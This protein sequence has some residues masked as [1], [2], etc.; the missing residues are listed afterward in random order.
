MSRY[1]PYFE[2]LPFGAKEMETGGRGYKEAQWNIFQFKGHWFGSQNEGNSNML[3]QVESQSD[4]LIT[5][6]PSLPRL[7]FCEAM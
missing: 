6:Y 2:S 1:L 4:W 7:A 5:T 3:S